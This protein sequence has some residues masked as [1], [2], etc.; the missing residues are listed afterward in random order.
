VNKLKF[1]LSGIPTLYSFSNLLVH[2]GLILGL[3]ALSLAFGLT[4]D[5][6]LLQVP[7]IILIM[8]LFFILFSLSTSLLSA[9][10]KDFANL[11]KSIVTPLLW[12]SGIFYNVDNLNIVWLQNVLLFNPITFFATAY[13]QAFYDKTWFWQ[14]SQALGAF[15]IVFLAT[16][17][18]TL[19]LY[20]NLHKEV[21]DVV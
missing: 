13:R 21:S 19:F 1:P 16:L 17:I 8:F 11:L 14:N 20:K 18:A 12:L 2:L 7:V 10:S 9:I 3:F 5:V 6:Y 15:G 4:P